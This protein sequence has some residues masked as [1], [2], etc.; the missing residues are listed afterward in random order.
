MTHDTLVSVRFPS[1]WLSH[2]PP[3]PATRPSA[4]ALL[5]ARFPSLLR[6]AH[7]GSGAAMAYGP[8]T[9]PGWWALVWIL[10]EHITAH[11]RTIG[12]DPASCGYPAYRQVKQKFGY[13]RVHVQPADGCVRALTHAAEH[14]SA[15][16]CEGCGGAGIWKHEA[17]SCFTLCSICDQRRHEGLRPD[18]W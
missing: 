12:V 11:A 1:H 16:I 4:L 2:A 5:T 6:L 15:T 10:S 14:R 9:G 18:E 8:E 7:L 17:G 3:V 13:L